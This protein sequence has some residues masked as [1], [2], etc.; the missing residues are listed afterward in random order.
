M[1]GLDL[2]PRLGVVWGWLREAIRGET[3]PRHAGFEKLLSRYISEQK[4]DGPWNEVQWDDVS[5]ESSG[6]HGGCTTELSSWSIHIRTMPA[7]G[8][9]KTYGIGH[10]AWTAKAPQQPG[11]HPQ[12]W[13]AGRGVR[14]QGVT[15]APGRDSKI[16]AGAETREEDY[17]PQSRAAEVACLECLPA[18]PTDW[19]T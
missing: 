3:T 12:Q 6:S 8:F 9:R 1:T 19:A 14:R 11:T 4:R 13:Q 10:G 7:P 16:S 18:Q 17:S 2:G 15:A 5:T